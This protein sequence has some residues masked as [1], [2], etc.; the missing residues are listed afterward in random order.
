MITRVCLNPKT[1]LRT[2]KR[3]LSILESCSTIN[4]ASHIADIKHELKPPVGNKILTNGY[5]KTMIVGGPN[6]RSDYH[7]EMGEELF[8]QMKGD[9]DLD[10]VLNDTER[11]RIRIKEGDIFLLPKGVPHSP[12]RYEDS[13]GLVFERERASHELDGMRWYVGDQISNEFKL[14]HNKNYETQVY[15]EQYFHCTDLGSQIKFAIESFKKFKQAN[16]VDL[17][18]YD[19]ASAPTVP[20]YGNGSGEAAL[21]EAG[22]DAIITP[23]VNLKMLL[24]KL[25]SNQTTVGNIFDSEFS[26]LSIHN[27]EDGRHDNRPP[28]VTMLNLEGTCHEMFLW[29]QSGSSTI[30]FIEDSEHRD[31]KQAEDA[32]TPSQRQPH[33]LLTP[34]DVLWASS[35]HTHQVKVKQQQSGDCLLCIYV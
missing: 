8:Y 22:R 32:D 14:N 29:Q 11:Q 4:L 1:F 26:V 13:I 7:I 5:I 3:Y 21:A 16:G 15:Y 20:S 27:G 18:S 9:M 34:G 17:Q 2:R 25:H 31:E 24:N 19:S 6:Q 23:P 28:S 12:Q 30:E 35:R 33:L 10:I